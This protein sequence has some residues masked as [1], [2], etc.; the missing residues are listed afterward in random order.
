MNSYQAAVRYARGY[1]DYYIS[2]FS[3]LRYL[4][5]ILNIIEYFNTIV[6]EG[7]SDEIVRFRRA[8]TLAIQIP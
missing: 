5:V 7:E 4:F 1:R 2:I 3:N 8:T 6:T